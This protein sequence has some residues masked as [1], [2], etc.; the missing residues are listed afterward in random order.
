MNFPDPTP[1]RANIK[2]KQRRGIGWFVGAA[3]TT[4][5]TL[6]FLAGLVLLLV[7]LVSLIVAALT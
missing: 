4:L 6:C 1:I 2:R 5:M 3:T 7:W